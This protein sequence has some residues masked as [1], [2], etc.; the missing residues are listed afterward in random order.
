MRIIVLAIF[1]KSARALLE[2]LRDQNPN[3][4]RFVA[5]RS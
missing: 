3:K 4:K 1:S 5:E 2:A